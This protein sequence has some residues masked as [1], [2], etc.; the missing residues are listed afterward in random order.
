MRLLVLFLAVS[1][2]V[3]HASRGQIS[4]GLNGQQLTRIVGRGVE[5]GDFNGDGFIDA[6]VSTETDNRIF[7]GDGIGSFTEGGLRLSTESASATGD[8]DG[9]GS[10]DV[11][12]GETVWL[13]DGRGGF[14]AQTGWIVRSETGELGRMKLA[15]LNG[16]GS[17][18]I[19]AIY[20]YFT[21]DK[22]YF[23]LRVFFNDGTGRF[24]DSGQRLGDGTIGL[25]QL[26]Q[27]ALGDVDGDGFCDAVTA[28]WRWDGSVPCPNRVWLN[29]GLGRFT[30][31]GQLLDEGA[32]HVHGL[33]LGDLNG[34]K[35]PDIVMGIQDAGRSGRVYLNDGTG[36][37]VRKGNLGGASGEKVLLADFDNDGDNDAFM[38]QSSPPNRVWVNDGAGTLRDSGLR[39]GNYS[40]WDAGTGDFNADGRPDVF[41]PNCVLGSSGFGTAPIQV[42]LNTTPS[43][44][45]GMRPSG[46]DGF[47]LGQNHPNPF[48]PTTVI[49]Y[50]L[51]AAGNARLSIYDLL[52]REI[53]ILA[54]GF[55]TRGEYP[56][57]WDGTD[58]RNIPVGSGVYYCQLRTDQGIFQKKMT[59]MR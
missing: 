20:I 5:M 54:N 31:S 36:R 17:P 52:G 7:F 15:D 27:I 40:T 56:L 23:A 22:P 14:S 33:A 38:P 58:A 3:P 13:N 57:L 21:A 46:P 25:G 8:I 4:F 19:F 12:A 34:D 49:R 9:N 29:D 39:L 48:N 45:I 51:A 16:D 26:G 2:T 55:H 24:T 28:G 6:L 32:S 41:V 11:I 50:R 47:E 1:M 42:W 53:K 18:D 59:L 37:F 44:G 30:D 10:L 43:A 35:R